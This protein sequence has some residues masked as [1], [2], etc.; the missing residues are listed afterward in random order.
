MLRQ[1]PN[2]RS[3]KQ[4][5]FGAKIDLLLLS[6]T[7]VIRSNFD[8]FWKG[9]VPQCPI[10]YHNVLCAMQKCCLNV[11]FIVLKIIKKTH[12][13]IYSI[14]TYS[15]DWLPSGFLHN[16]ALY[17]HTVFISCF[18]IQ[19]LRSFRS[20]PNAENLVWIRPTVAKIFKVKPVYRISIYTVA[21]C[22][23][24]GEGRKCLIINTWWVLM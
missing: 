2:P 13:H 19:K 7:F 6:S 18:G 3:T 1:K 5:Q 16:Y 20:K 15:V 17:P 4:G 10:L 23:C 8:L 21:K 22:T 24:F 9:I 14:N 12:T 11:L